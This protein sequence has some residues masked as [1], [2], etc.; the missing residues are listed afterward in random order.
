ML[1]K[2]LPGLDLQTVD[3]T[4]ASDPSLKYNC[5]GFAIGNNRWWEPS[6][7]VPGLARNPKNYW[8]PGLNAPPNHHI[9]GFIRLFESEGYLRCDGGAWEDGFR[10]VVLA[11]DENDDFKHVC[12]LVA[13]DIWKSKWGDLSD[14]AHE[15]MIMRGGRY[16][17][18]FVYMK[19]EDA[20]MVASTGEAVAKAKPTEAA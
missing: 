3:W 5:I 18:N 12:L 16:G 10:K 2:Y 11:S 17:T 19:K 9:R 1:Q 4:T 20:T 6:S 8:P 15:L 13:P 7:G 14:F